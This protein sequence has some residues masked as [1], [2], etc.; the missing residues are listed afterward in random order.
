M[1]KIPERLLPEI[2]YALEKDSGFDFKR[3]GNNLRFGI[4]PNCGERECFINLDRP[5]RVSCGRLNNCGW[6]A[7]VREL[8]PDIFDNLSR[9][10]PA[11]E[12]NPNATADAYLVANRGFSIESIKG[13]VYAGECEKCQDGRILSLH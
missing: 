9:R 7:T 11:T 1:R 12:E 13:G 2:R 5:Y 3:N 4:C 6:N 10:Y 8:Y